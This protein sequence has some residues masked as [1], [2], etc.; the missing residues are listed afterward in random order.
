[1]TTACSDGRFS[2]PERAVAFILQK[3][4]D[5]IKKPPTKLSVGGKNS[6]KMKKPPTEELSVG[7]ELSLN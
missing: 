4:S 7:G 2:M 1:M 3:N 6:G 5:N